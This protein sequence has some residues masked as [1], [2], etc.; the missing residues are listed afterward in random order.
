M[1]GS[2]VYSSGRTITLAKDVFVPTLGMLRGLDHK[3]IGL[4]AQTSEI[5]VN[6]E[7]VNA[8]RI[9]WFQPTIQQMQPPM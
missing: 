1:T 7:G 3:I 8:G 9:I 6:T 2:V 5:G 4:G